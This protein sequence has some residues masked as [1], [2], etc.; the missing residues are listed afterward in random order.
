[1]QAVEVHFFVDQRSK[2]RGSD[3]KYRYS[4]VLI[5]CNCSENEI[6]K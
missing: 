2:R 6:N 4:S 5:H 1:M 3:K